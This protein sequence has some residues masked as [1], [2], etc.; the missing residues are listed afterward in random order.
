MVASVVDESSDVVVGAAVELSSVLD[1][2]AVVVL[3]EG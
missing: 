1:G 3:G 2:A